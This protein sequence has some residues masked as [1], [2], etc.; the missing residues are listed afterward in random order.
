MVSAHVKRTLWGVVVAVSCSA[1]ALADSPVRYVTALPEYARFSQNREHFIQYSRDTGTDLFHFNRSSGRFLRAGTFQSNSSSTCV[2]NSGE[3]VAIDPTSGG[4][5]YFDA[6]AQPLTREPATSCVPTEAGKT[7]R[8]G[9]TAKQ[10]AENRRLLCALPATLTLNAEGIPAHIYDIYGIFGS[11]PGGRLLVE[12]AT[13]PISA[14]TAK[15]QKY[16]EYSVVAVMELRELRRGHKQLPNYC[17]AS[18]LSAVEGSCALVKADDSSAF[19]TRFASAAERTS[20]AGPA[21][22][23]LRLTQSAPNGLTAGK[24]AVTVE[25]LVGEYS[26]NE[27]QSKFE[28]EVPS[29]GYSIRTFNVSLNEGCGHVITLKSSNPRLRTQAFGIGDLWCSH[30]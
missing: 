24:T 2:T 13:T 8:S 12:L 27:T 19:F 25:W 7:F 21:T 15:Y 9:S 29:T 23:E 6:S 22:C 26:A 5:I 16:N 20:A 28:A 30:Y 10:R 14:D 4:R 1:A 3:V 18:E 11:L 17:L